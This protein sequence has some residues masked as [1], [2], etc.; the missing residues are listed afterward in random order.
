LPLSK[1]VCCWYNESA[2][3]LTVND[4]DDDDDDCCMGWP[5]TLRTGVNAAWVQELA[6][7]N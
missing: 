7:E 2:A 1:G 3:C 6:V 5:S 4:D